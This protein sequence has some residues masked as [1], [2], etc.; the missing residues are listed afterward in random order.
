[1]TSIFNLSHQHEAVMRHGNAV[2]FHSLWFFLVALLFTICSCTT[3][4]QVTY[5]QD[6]D[7]L[8]DTLAEVRPLTTINAFDELRII[9]TAENAASVAAF[10]KPMFIE[11]SIGDRGIST[12]N[13]IMTYLVDADGNIDFPIIGRIHVAGMT[14]DELT[15]ELKAMISQYV[16]NPIVSIDPLAFPI[17]VIGEVN[18]PGTVY[19]QAHHN[20]IID[21]LS[22][23]HDLTIYG[24]RKNV[25]ILH[26]ENNMLVKHR[27]DL[28]AAST[29]TDPQCYLHQ[30]DVVIVEPNDARRSS[31]NYDSM[32]Q[33]NLSFIS[34]IVG[35]VSVLSSLAIAIWK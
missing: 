16:V 7:Q 33:Q 19:I 14:T 23:V 3:S 31:S 27:V 13:Q 29:L 34:T 17:Q 22:K 35:V 30:Q 12:V 26:R 1:M 21:A 6:V 18:A 9:V 32:K 20:N 8:P 15:K 2:P 24:N 28:T 4:N 25:L 11:R 10:N 5:F